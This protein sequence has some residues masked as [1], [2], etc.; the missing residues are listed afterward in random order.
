[1]RLLHA[2]L[3]ALLA[4]SRSAQASRVIALP[5]CGAPSHV[6]IMWKVCRELAS[7]GHDILVRPAASI[8]FCGPAAQARLMAY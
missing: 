2:A 7:R 3:L 6:F 5:L 4:L 1:M 8:L